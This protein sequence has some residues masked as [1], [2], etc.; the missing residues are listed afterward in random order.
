M[1]IEIM[2]ENS[3]NKTTPIGFIMASLNEKMN[4]VRNIILDDGVLSRNTFYVFMKVEENDILWD[5][6]EELSILKQLSKQKEKDVY[7]LRLK[8]FPQR[9]IFLF[10]IVNLPSITFMKGRSWC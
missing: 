6:L 10:T 2:D 3:L 7:T 4:S 5:E 9:V 1:L 8:S